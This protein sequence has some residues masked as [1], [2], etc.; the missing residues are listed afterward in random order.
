VITHETQPIAGQ[1]PGTSGLR[2]KVKVFAQPNYAENFI[3]SVFDVVERPAN[4]TLV[5]GG[6]GRYH[7]RT[8]IQQAIRMAA[9]NGYGR[10]LVGQG[11]PFDPGGLQCDPSIW[12]QRRPCP[13]GQPQSRRPGRRFRHQI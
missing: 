7:N 8:V 1:K 2:K 5:I 10:V 12:R 6:D 11:D 3:Q 9:A 4:A 13:V